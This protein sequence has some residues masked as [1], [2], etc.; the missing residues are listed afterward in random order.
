[1]QASSAFPP[2]FRLNNLLY[3]H[4]AH[5]WQVSALH[6]TQRPHFFDLVISSAAVCSFA[7]GLEEAELQI[8]DELLVVC[9]IADDI[10][11]MVLVVCLIADD[12]TGIALAVCLI[13]DGIISMDSAVCL[14]LITDLTDCLSFE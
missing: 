11:G 6:P 13:A 8:S 1:M 4:L 14:L 10:T 3:M 2:F 7:A 12:I 9:L 5:F